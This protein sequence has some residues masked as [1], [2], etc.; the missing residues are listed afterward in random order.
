MLQWLWAGVLSLLLI[1]AG[2]ALTGTGLVLVVAGAQAL[3]EPDDVGHTIAGVLFALVGAAGVVGGVL[4]VRWLL[5]RG[6]KKLSGR[7]P[8]SLGG[9]SGEV[10]GGFFGGDGCGGGEGGGG[11]GSC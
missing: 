11:G 3:L 10:Y 8:P 9:G 1:A 4:T 2:L 5:P 6:V 7:K